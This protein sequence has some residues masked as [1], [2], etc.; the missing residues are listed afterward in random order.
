VTAALLGSAALMGERVLVTNWL[1]WIAGV[2]ASLA[3][4]AGL[5]VVAGPTGEGRRAI[6]RRFRTLLARGRGA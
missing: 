6:A 3:L 1:T 5:A 2:G 4:V